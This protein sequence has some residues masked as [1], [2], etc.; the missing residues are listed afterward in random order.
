MYCTS[1]TAS[2]FEFFLQLH[3]PY[4]AAYESTATEHDVVRQVVQE[5]VAK[6]QGANGAPNLLQMFYREPAR[7]A[8]TFQNY[9]F[10]TRVM[11][12]SSCLLRVPCTMWPSALGWAP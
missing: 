12:A 6:W 3:W 2:R 8:Y 10:M 11:Q 4:M 7:Y 1:I 9:V 5:P